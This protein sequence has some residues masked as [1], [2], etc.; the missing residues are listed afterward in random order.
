MANRRKIDHAAGDNAVEQRQVGRRQAEHRA[1]QDGELDV[2][3]AEPTSRDDGHLE[4]HAAG[5]LLV[6][7]ADLVLEIVGQLHFPHQARD[8]LRGVAQGCRV[9]GIRASPA[10]PR[11]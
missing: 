9:G 6:P 11:S 7:G 2:A 8:Q 3:E 1:D 5:Q 4:E 10:R